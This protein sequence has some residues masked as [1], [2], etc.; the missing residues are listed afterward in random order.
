MLQLNCRCWHLCYKDLAELKRSL[1]R[2]L[3]T[4]LVLKGVNSPMKS[5]A[6]LNYSEPQDLLSSTHAKSD[7]YIY[8]IYPHIFKFSTH[9][10]YKV[11]Y[12]QEF[13]I[14]IFIFLHIEVTFMHSVANS[15]ARNDCVINMALERFKFW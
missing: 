3:L 11:H 1:F 4:L 5:H 13:F 12:L 7:T 10:S 9:T 8:F 15:M 14:F 6:N 2:V